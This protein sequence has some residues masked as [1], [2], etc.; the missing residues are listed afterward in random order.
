MHVCLYIRVCL[1]MYAY[2]NVLYVCVW[3]RMLVCACVRVRDLLYVLFG[4]FFFVFLFV[5]ARV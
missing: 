1:C 3:L 4:C 5:Y 2:V